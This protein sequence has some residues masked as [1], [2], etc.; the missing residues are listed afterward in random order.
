MSFESDFDDLMTQTIT[1][2]AV[3]SRDLYGKRTFA[4]AVSYTAR[5]VEQQVRVVD[6]EGRENVGT[7]TVW[8]HGHATSGVPNV[9]P[10]SRLTL[11]DGSTPAILNFSV[12]PDEDGDHHFKIVCGAAS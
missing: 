4:T 10:D 6:F 3:S 9:G 1:I 8:A 11:P 5:V 7:H 2:A 12:Y